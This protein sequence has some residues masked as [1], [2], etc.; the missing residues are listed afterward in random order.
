MHYGA[1]YGVGGL[2]Y[3]MGI[4]GKE[5]EDQ[6][7]SFRE[8][9]KLVFALEEEATA[10]HIDQAEMFMFINNSLTESTF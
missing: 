10:G 2:Q 9:A 7:S 3:R 1:G 4:R 5:E 8:L 6:I